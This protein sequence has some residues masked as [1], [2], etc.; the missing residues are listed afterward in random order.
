M[1]ALLSSGSDTGILPK[2]FLSSS[3]SKQ[4]LCSKLL[5]GNEKVHDLS[6]RCLNNAMEYWEPRIHETLVE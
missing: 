1:R 2:L 6:Q 3:H 5:V 4:L